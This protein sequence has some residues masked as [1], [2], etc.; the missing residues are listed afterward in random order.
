MSY[1]IGLLV[2]LLVYW[3]YYWFIGYIGLLVILGLL[4]NI[5][6]KFKIEILFCKFANIITYQPVESNKKYND[7][8]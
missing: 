4:Q 2:I 1:I 6:N 8:C 7:Y 3:L 5:I